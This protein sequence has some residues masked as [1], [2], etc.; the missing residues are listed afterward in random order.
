MKLWQGH[1]LT[2]PEVDLQRTFEG[3]TLVLPDP[4]HL[5]LKSVGK[6]TTKNGEVLAPLFP[7]TPS[8]VVNRIPGLLAVVDTENH[9]VYED[10]LVVGVAFQG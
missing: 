10:Y 6:V 1:E 8:G 9:S 7:P 2:P 5:G 3:K 4:I